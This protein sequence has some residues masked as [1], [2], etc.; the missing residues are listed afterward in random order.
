MRA[1]GSVVVLVAACGRVS[2]DPL[3]PSRDDGSIDIF[4]GPDAC[5]LAASPANQRTPAVAGASAGFVVAWDDDRS[6]S[7]EIYATRV[8]LAGAVQD[9][10]GLPVGAGGPYARHA[11]A[12]AAGAGEALVVWRED[13]PGPGPDIFSSIVTTT[14]VGTPVNLSG[15]GFTIGTRPA[16]ASSGT[17]FLV[18]WGNHGGGSD[19]AAAT[20]TSDGVA[21]PWFTICAAANGQGEPSVTYGAGYFVAWTDD[22]MT[23]GNNDIFAARLGDNVALDC[24]P[25]STGVTSEAQ[26][27]A[28]FASGAYGIAWT[29]NRNA[30]PDIYG[31]RL[32]TA[33]SVLDPAGLAFTT[34]AGI[35]DQASVASSTLSVI[36]WIDATANRV[37]AS[38]VNTST[39]EIGPTITLP[40]LGTLP[41]AVAVGVVENEFMVVA[42]TTGATTGQDVEGWFVDVSSIV[43]GPFEIVGSCN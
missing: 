42:E 9:L 38:V 11:P 37:Q 25:V 34:A 17:N 26:P 31:A 35:Q 43:H 5:A 2:F 28:T 23:A 27:T 10:G 33:G 36:A 7:S 14:G 12:V 6:G 15:G 3:S 39:L 8:S 19:L 4:G 13:S 29:D 41:Q 24:I 32:T 18:A 40:T 30:D 1:G 21:Q 22:R 20:V 16:V